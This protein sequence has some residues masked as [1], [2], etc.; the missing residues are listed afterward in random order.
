MKVN[1]DDL[2][3]ILMGKFKKW[4][5]NHQPVHMFSSGNDQA[6]VNHGD[7]ERWGPLRSRASDPEDDL[8]RIGALQSA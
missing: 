5:P 1:W 4:Q 3:P 7:R 2:F 6:L 8:L